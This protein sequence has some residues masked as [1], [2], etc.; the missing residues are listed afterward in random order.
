ML[1]SICFTNSLRARY[2]RHT[3]ALRV[4]YVGTAYT[5][6]QDQKGHNVRTVEG[7]LKAALG[8][9]FPCAGRTDKVG[10]C[11]CLVDRL[12]DKYFCCAH[13]TCQRCRKLYLFIRLTQ[14]SQHV[15]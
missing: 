11:R 15:A 4:G 3:F 10:E 14:M 9:N 5:G 12:D 1:S 6:F 7:D 8:E 2:K 13:R